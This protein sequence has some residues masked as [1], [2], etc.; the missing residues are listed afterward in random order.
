ME[1]FPQWWPLVS[2]AINIT[3]LGVLVKLTR[4]FSHIEFKVNMMWAVFARRYGT[5]NEEG[6][7]IGD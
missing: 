5:R 2:M 1:Q 4:T 3:I 7:D 6:K